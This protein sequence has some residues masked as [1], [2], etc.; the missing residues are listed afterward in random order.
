M[1]QKVNKG[2]QK[3]ENMAEIWDIVDKDGNYLNIKWSREDND[4]IPEGYY[5]PCVEIW[6]RVGDKMLITQR[7]PE[8]SEGLKYDVPGGAVVSGEDILVGAMRELGEEVGINVSTD[9]LVCL[10]TQSKGKVYA[11]SY[12]LILEKLPSLVLQPTEVVGYKLVDK[13]ELESMKDQL[14]AG[15]YRRYLVYK[16]SIFE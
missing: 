16:D 12:L 13:S 7:H 14:T 15:T 3:G 6:V 1:K 8:K 4:K 5:H 11:V 9:K 2:L 10:G